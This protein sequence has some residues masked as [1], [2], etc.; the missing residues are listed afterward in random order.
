MLRPLDDYWLHDL[1]PAQLATI[2]TQLHTQA[3][4][5]DHEVRPALIAAREDWTSHRNA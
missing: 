2:A 3:D 4:H 5:L 1:D